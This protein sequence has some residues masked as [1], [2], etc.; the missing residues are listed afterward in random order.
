MFE[1]KS[2]YLKT[3]QYHLIDGRGRIVGVVAIPE[4][5]IQSLRGYHLRK[6]SERTDHHASH[7]L[8]DATGFW[9]IADI[10]DA[11]LP[12]A[13]MEQKEIAIP[14]KTN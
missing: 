8:N 4:H 7:Y 12:E 3:E 1:D 11:M 14:D 10:N 9:R 13:L 2:R 6:D 5:L